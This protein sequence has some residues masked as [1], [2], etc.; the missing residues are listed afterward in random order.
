MR[1]GKSS[2]IITMNIV[3]EPLQ[4]CVSVFASARHARIPS[5]GSAVNAVRVKIVKGRKTGYA[6]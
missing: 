6:K 2:L 5:V 1:W 4:S 3:V